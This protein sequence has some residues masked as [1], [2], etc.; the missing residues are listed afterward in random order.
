MSNEVTEAAAFFIRVC[1]EHRRLFPLR[2][3]LVVADGSDSAADE[4]KIVEDVGDIVERYRLGEGLDD[5]PYD[6]RQEF[7]SLL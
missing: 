2:N 1:V 4:G 6:L 3:I 5:M 7:R